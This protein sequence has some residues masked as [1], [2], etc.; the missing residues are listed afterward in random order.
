MNEIFVEDK[1]MNK[2]KEKI[3]GAAELNYFLRFL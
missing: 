2:L 1:N 3:L